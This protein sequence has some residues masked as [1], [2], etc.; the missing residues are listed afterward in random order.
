MERRQPS[1]EEV[2][3]HTLIAED[4][5]GPLVPEKIAPE[6]TTAHPRLT[7][8]SPVAPADVSPERRISAAGSEPVQMA[9]AALPSPPAPSFPPPPPSLN[10]INPIYDA[11]RPTP[12]TRRSPGGLAAQPDS[13]MSPLPRPPS[14]VV[15]GAPSADD[16]PRRLRP[17]PSIRTPGASPRRDNA[18]SVRWQ[19][20]AAAAI[21]DL[22]IVAAAAIGDLAIVVPEDDR[23]SHPVMEV[24]PI[25]PATAPS[26]PAPALHP[27]WTEPGAIAAATKDGWFGW[28]NSHTGSTRVKMCY[29]PAPSAP[30]ESAST[31]RSSN[32]STD[33]IA[34][35]TANHTADGFLWL[36]TPAEFGIE[37][38]R[39]EIPLSLI[40]TITSSMACGDFDPAAA[41]QLTIR[42]KPVPRA[43]GCGGRAKAAHAG[44]QLRLV[45]PTLLVRDVWLL[46]IPALCRA[47]TAA[48]TAATA[49]SLTSSWPGDDPTEPRL[50]RVM[51]RLYGGGGGGVSVSIPEAAAAMA[52]LAPYFDPQL[53]EHR[54]QNVMVGVE[55]TLQN[56]DFAGVASVVCGRPELRYLMADWSA[57]AAAGGSVVGR[58]NSRLG[59]AELHWFLAAA[60]HDLA[61]PVAGQSPRESLADLIAAHADPAVP[62]GPAD[63]AAAP[64][65]LSAGGFESLIRARS[66]L[67]NQAEDGPPDLS[68]PLDQYCIYAS[69]QT[70]L[71][72]DLLGPAGELGYKL[73][74]EDGCRCVDL[75]CWDGDDGEPVVCSSLASMFKVSVGRVLRTIAAT[76]F[77][78]SH[79]PLIVLVEV[80]C[81][82]AQQRSLARQLEA[83]LGDAIARAPTQALPMLPSPK[84]L[85]DKI[86]IA[87]HDRR[88]RRAAGGPQGGT[89]AE[90]SSSDIEVSS[91]TD[92]TL[93]RPV[94]VS[95]M[96]A[97]ETLVEELAALAYFT[98]ERCADPR[99]VSTLLEHVD[100]G[101]VLEMRQ[102]ATPGRLLLVVP[103]PP[104]NLEDAVKNVDPTPGWH[105][106]CNMVGMHCQKP[107]L[108]M[109]LNR[110]HFRKGA[111]AATTT[112]Y[113]LMAPVPPAALSRSVIPP[114]S[115]RTPLRLVLTVLSG[116]NPGLSD[117]VDPGS[118]I[119]PFVKAQVVEFPRPA[120]TGATFSAERNGLNPYWG[121]VLGFEV[122]R[123]D[124]ALLRL[125]LRDGKE[126]T[127][128][129]ALLGQFVARVADLREGYQ[130]LPVCS[131]HGHAVPGVT[132]FVRIELVP[133]HRPKGGAAAAAL[134][135]LLRRDAARPPTALTIDG[136]RTSV[137]RLA[138][139]R[140][141]LLDGSKATTMA[142][143]VDAVLDRCAD[144]GLVGVANGPG[145]ELQLYRERTG[146][147]VPTRQLDASARED[148]AVASLVPGVVALYGD[149]AALRRSVLLGAQDA[150]SALLS[151]QAVLLAG[152]GPAGPSWRAKVGRAWDAFVRG[153]VFC[154][155][156]TRPSTV[157]AVLLDQLANAVAAAQAELATEV[158]DAATVS[159]RR[160]AAFHALD[161][162]QEGWVVVDADS[163][164][165]PRMQPA[166]I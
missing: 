150:V 83:T 69:H 25:A 133:A 123:P 144:A 159:S 54:L 161:P 1:A 112:G 53:L 61:R 155:P 85:T 10:E 98:T 110:G 60:Q 97:S 111:A 78:S 114:T 63:T 48:A 87:V 154:A 74:L 21:G 128:G 62:A 141:K 153:V 71:L 147:A 163:D 121:E 43:G 80:R 105:T 88:G 73:L 36:R 145:G 2:G 113:V 26:A 19:G 77:A 39:W 37:A 156:A 46:A 40:D 29:R 116:Q 102:G 142:G 160:V 12:S 151:A 136:L 93:K 6:A 51:A 131:R 27:V 49:P 94:A 55:P 164:S 68:R 13:S 17:K 66:P 30:S 106:G 89:A 165:Q 146:E 72:G 166:E 7:E 52:E 127:R 28:A 4:Q 31:R 149:Y 103:P 58:H 92:D 84:E 14:P 70:Q 126:G 64:P 118:S 47:A 137:E 140:A 90:A 115:S 117:A 122:A 38:T 5:I 96:A 124:R 3:Y 158:A 99:V 81:S 33:G 24:H 120:Q 109:Q 135:T 9:M 108:W 50:A 45:A 107:D 57:A 130:Y 56:V 162:V 34:T 18:R 11:A 76:A 75:R 132:L 35:A 59:P 67:L 152:R 91:S 44:E 104:R 101:A 143:V 22:A 8:V 129:S 15:P 16:A 139:A 86:I 20:A 95:L 65:L 42:L 32:G 100:L 157:P 119:D 79:C 41:L 82:A 23:I 134:A 138:A 148:D 125:M